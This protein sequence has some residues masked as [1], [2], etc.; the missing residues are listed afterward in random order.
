MALFTL[1]Y[2][3][4]IGDEKKK[5]Y[6]AKRTDFFKAKYSYKKLINNVIQFFFAKKNFFFLQVHC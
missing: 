3:L 4:I 5:K 6:N 2:K 1:A